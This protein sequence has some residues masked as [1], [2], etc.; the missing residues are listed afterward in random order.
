ML[1]GMAYLWLEYCNEYRARAAVLLDCYE[2]CMKHDISQPLPEDVE[3]FRSEHAAM[4]KTYLA[5]YVEKG[6]RAQLVKMFEAISSNSDHSFSLSVAPSSIPEA[7]K[8]VFVETS[9]DIVPGTVVALY[10]GRVYQRF[11]LFDDNFVQSLMP[12]ENFMLMLRRDDNLIDPR[13]LEG[14]PSNPYAVGQFINHC[15]AKRHPN[16]YQVRC[17]IW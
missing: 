17:P 14:V 6:I 3:K 15:G 2:H 13:N 1:S 5:P 12:D 11:E 10:P 16:I 8:G 4:T 7:G 9:R